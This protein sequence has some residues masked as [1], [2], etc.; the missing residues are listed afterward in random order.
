[1]EK[2]LR[3]NIKNALKTVTAS[4]SPSVYELLQT[5][6]GYKTVEDMIIK[7][8]ANDN[9]TASAAIPQVENMI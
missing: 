9:M 8:M 3:A 7:L 4:N 2:K 6:N 1:M 5:E